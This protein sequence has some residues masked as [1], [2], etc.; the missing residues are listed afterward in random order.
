M[1]IRS[2]F[3]H[4]RVFPASLV[5]LSQAVRPNQ[6][7]YFSV[8]N[9]GDIF[10]RDLIR[11]IYRVDV[12]NHRRGG[13]RLL[14]VGSIAHMV[15]AGDVVSGIGVKSR[16]IPLA[17]N[18]SPLIVGLRGPISREVFE[19]AGYDVSN[20]RFLLD[21]GLLIRELLGPKEI[22][23]RQQA[24]F[25][26]HY[27]ERWR[28]R[29]GLPAG[30]KLVDIDASPVAVAEQIQESSLVYASSLHGLIFA[31]ALGRPCVFVRPQSDEGL[32][33]YEDYFEAIGLTYTHPARDIWEAVKKPAPTSPATLSIKYEDFSF[34]TIERLQ[35][36][37]VA[38]QS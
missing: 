2:F 33:K 10:G 17:P 23:P 38:V 14:C 5:R 6:S 26:P 37:G 31:H 8:G 27:R 3:W 20:V 32:L 24:V 28:Y 18:P 34:P 30:L 11:H 1:V 22:E 15:Q 16:D 36:T 29:N 25:I 4:D 35:E 19:R 21:P 12:R 13:N 7:R 9:A